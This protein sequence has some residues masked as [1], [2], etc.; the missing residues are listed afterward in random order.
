MARTYFERM[1]KMAQKA[2]GG[3]KPSTA[4]GGKIGLT[5]FWLSFVFGEYVGGGGYLISMGSIKKREI[6]CV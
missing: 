4:N 5:L 2:M 1:A 3:K 6:E